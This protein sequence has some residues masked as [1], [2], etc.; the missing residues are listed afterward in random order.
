MSYLDIWYE[1]RYRVKE[2]VKYELAE[3]LISESNLNTNTYIFYHKTPLVLLVYQ[4]YTPSQIAYL[5]IK[6]TC[7]VFI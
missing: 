2:K 1:L 7:L 5:Y 6:K 3:L 4:L